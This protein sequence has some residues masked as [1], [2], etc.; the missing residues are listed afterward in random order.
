MRSE[1]LDRHREANGTAWSP[2]VRALLDRHSLEPGSIPRR[3]PRLTRRDVEAFLTARKPAAAS[4]PEPATTAAGVPAATMPPAPDNVPQ[5]AV[6]GQPPKRNT[7]QVC[8]TR[9][10][11]TGIEAAALPAALV[12]ALVE[13][14]GSDE[15]LSAALAPPR[16]LL[17]EDLQADADPA[18]CVISGAGELNATAIRSRLAAAAQAAAAQAG[19]ADGTEAD[20]HI[21]ISAAAGVLPAPAPD[22]GARVILTVTPGAPSVEAVPGVAGSTQIAIRS[23]ADAALAIR[24]AS[25]SSAVGCT[26]ALRAVFAGRNTATLSQ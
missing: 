15:A 20:V 16:R 4:Q 8:S 3:A 17:L 26:S 21:I 10:D 1:L 7:L 9:L 24:S 19:T 13:I 11:L 18:R 6:A 2:A 23:M 22:S 12:A 25:V 14:A 5:N